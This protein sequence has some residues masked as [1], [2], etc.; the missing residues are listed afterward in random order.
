MHAPHSANC[1]LINVII[2]KHK[3]SIMKFVSNALIIVFYRFVV[4]AALK[5]SLFKC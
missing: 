3:K 4:A 1:S 2:A 5:I